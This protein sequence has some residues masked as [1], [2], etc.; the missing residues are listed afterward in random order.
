MQ[1]ICWF[2][3]GHRIPERKQASCFCKS[4]C[5]ISD[6]IRVSI[7]QSTEIVIPKF[8]SYIWISENGWPK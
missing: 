4:Y 5:R 6:F 2:F 1:Y 8:E 3:T 7:I